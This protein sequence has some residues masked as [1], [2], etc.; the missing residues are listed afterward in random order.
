MNPFFFLY[1][2]N[3]FGSSSPLVVTQ[4]L[5]RRFRALTNK[6]QLIYKVG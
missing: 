3:P 6:M 2:N 4:Q 5:P 1:F